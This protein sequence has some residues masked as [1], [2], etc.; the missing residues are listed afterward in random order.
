M[1]MQDNFFQV[2]KDIHFLADQHS[3]TSDDARASDEVIQ[4]ELALF[5]ES[6]EIDDLKLSQQ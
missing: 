5:D 3:L 1:S 2:I 6:I 4:L